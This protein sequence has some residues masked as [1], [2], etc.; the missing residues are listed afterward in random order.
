M[1]L[2]ANDIVS[3]VLL[4]RHSSSLLLAARNA[5]HSLGY[6]WKADDLA[7]IATAIDS[8]EGD[9]AVNINK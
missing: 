9:R 2:V 3:F 7:Q 5:S 4:F 8:Y 1:P 6:S